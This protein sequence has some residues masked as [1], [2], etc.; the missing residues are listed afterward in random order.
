MSNIKAK[1]LY[2]SLLLLGA[3]LL[4]ICLCAGIVWA[5]LSTTFTKENANIGIADLSSTVSNG[6]ITISNDLDCVMRVAPLSQDV[7]NSL[8]A[9]TTHWTKQYNGWYYYNSIISAN[10]NPTVSVTDISATNILVELMQANYAT[11]TVTVDQNQVQAPTGGFIIEWGP[12]NFDKNNTILGGNT[13]DGNSLGN[14]SQSVVAAFYGNS[15]IGSFFGGNTTDNYSLQINNGIIQVNTSSTSTPSWQDI[16][17]DVRLYNN[18]TVPMVMSF[19]ITIID[20]TVIEDLSSIIN[21]DNW[22]SSDGSH[23]VSKNVVLPGQYLTVIS[24][25]ATVNTEDIKL[26]DCTTC[27]GL[28]NISTDCTTCGGT[29]LVDDAV[30][31]AVCTGTG[32]IVNTCTTCNGAGEIRNPNTTPF[33]LNVSVVDSVSYHLNYNTSTNDPYLKWLDGLDTSADNIYYTQYVNKVN[34][35]DNSIGN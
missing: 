22:S 15:T 18:S 8:K 10:S 30:Q 26:I 3:T 16:S 20:T 9:D 11:E 1:Y 27:N 13:T 21:T 31:C 28:G 2:A 34:S 19:D 29:G 25:N 33:S 7:E 12:W 32:Q 4:A 35:G 6:S 24:S 14:F 23:F 17:S 5:A